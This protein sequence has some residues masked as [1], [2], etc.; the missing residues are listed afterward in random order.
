MDERLAVEAEIGA[1]PRVAF[2]PVRL[3]EIEAGRIDSVEAGRPRDQ[4]HA[5]HGMELGLS[6]GHEPRAQLARQVARP[7]EEGGRPW[8]GAGERLKVEDG[9]DRLDQKVEAD[10][11]GRASA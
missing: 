9:R 3:S 10:G 2:E 5:T 8:D 11:A 4:H 6:V 1:D 7:V